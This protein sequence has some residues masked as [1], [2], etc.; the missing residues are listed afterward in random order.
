[1]FVQ[2]CYHI[3]PHI[4]FCF[5]AFFISPIISCIFPLQIHFL[6]YFC[7]CSVTSNPAHPPLHAYSASRTFA[8]VDALVHLRWPPSSH[9]LSMPYHVFDVLRLESHLLVTFFY[10]SSL[11]LFLLW[12]VSGFRVS[13]TQLSASLFS[14]VFPRGSNWRCQCPVDA[15]LSQELWNQ[16]FS[17]F[18]GRGTAQIG[19]SGQRAAVN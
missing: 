6:S 11:H 12:N 13:A 18:A 16:V 3:R 2:F 9:R 1:M 7:P 4:I 15:E 10:S 17:M 14:N 8:Y 19:C 5:I